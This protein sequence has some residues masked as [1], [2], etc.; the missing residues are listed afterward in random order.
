MNRKGRVSPA[1]WATESASML[2]K[3]SAAA[4]PPMARKKARRLTD[5]MRLLGEPLRLDK[6]MGLWGRALEWE[7]R[8]M[9]RSFVRRHRMRPVAPRSRSGCADFRHRAR[10]RHR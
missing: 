5:R 3:G 6:L 8:L 7:K 1:A 10:T 9:V 4:V 2:M